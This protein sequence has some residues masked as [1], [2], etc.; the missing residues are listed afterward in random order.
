MWHQ[1]F[2]RKQNPKG[3]SKNFPIEILFLRD[4][5]IPQY[6]EQG[7]V[8]IGILGENEVLEKDKNIDIISRLGFAAC[9]L[10][11]AIPKDEEYSGISY[12]E[13]KKLLLHI[14]KS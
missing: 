9:N 2:Q 12:F 1:Y 3:H 5:D 7:V 13:D 11:L 10:C 6:V 14:L 8:D 4:D